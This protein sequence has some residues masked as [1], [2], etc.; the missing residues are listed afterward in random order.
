MELLREE[1]HFTL[2]RFGN[3]KAL[4]LDGLQ[5]V[6]FQSQWNVIGNE[7]NILISEIFESPSKIEE[8]NNT[9]ISLIP[10]KDVLTCM[11]DFCPISLCNVYHHCSTLK[12]FACMNKLIVPVKA[13]MS[14]P[15]KLMTTLQW[16]RR[17]SIQPEI[18]KVQ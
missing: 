15:V 2:K 16:L 5:A 11:K 3:Y 13:V 1:I 10:K 9:L 4:G 14:P 18:K 17:F 8:I 12:A 7:F 6:F